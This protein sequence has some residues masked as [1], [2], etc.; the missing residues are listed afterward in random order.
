MNNEMNQEIF[1]SEEIV[2]MEK[3]ETLLDKGKN[4]LKAGVSKAKDAGKWIKEN[5]TDAGMVA[6]EAAAGFGI[7]VLTAA[8]LK[9][10]KNVDRRSE[11]LYQAS[12][13]KLGEESQKEIYI[14]K[15]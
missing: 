6:V 9:S 7:L 11:D 12:M 14:V 1:E 3:K 2:E 5:P 13:E 10:T 15:Q 8:G 4:L